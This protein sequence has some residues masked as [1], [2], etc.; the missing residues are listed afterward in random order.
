MIKS[1]KFFVAFCLSIIT[2]YVIMM[3]ILSLFSFRN[4]TITQWSNNYYVP[5][6]GSSYNRFRE[7]KPNYFYDILFIG[8]SRTFRGYDPLIF[9]EDS[10]STYNLGSSNQTLRNSYILAE[11]LIRSKNTSTLIVDIYSYSLSDISFE[12]SMDLVSNIPNPST[13]MKIQARELDIRTT[14][15]FLRRLFTL[16][17]KPVLKEKD[18]VAFGFCKKTNKLDS[19]LIKKIAQN[20]IQSN[21]VEIIKEELDYIYKISRL[22][23]ERDIQLIFTTSPTSVFFTEKDREKMLDIIL[24]IFE[25]T[26][27]IYLDYSKK[28]NLDSKDYFFDEGHMNYQGVEIFNKTLIKDLKTILKYK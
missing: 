5:L 25:S 27:D 9:K 12:S 10:L 23:K 11:D 2:I 14:N 15:N 19:A 13:A 8:S 22:C 17:E 16:N 21:P 18:A 26:G 7:F 6:G 28:L 3:F 4:N 1:I 24:P 20:D